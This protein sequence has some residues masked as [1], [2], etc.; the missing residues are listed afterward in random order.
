MNNA[1]K[2][3]RPGGRIQITTTREGD[4]A[5][6]T[7]RD[8]GI[9]IPTEQLT[10]VFD[11]FSQV[12]PAISHAHGG[13][14]IGLYLVRRLVDMHKGT[15]EALSEGPDRG[16]AFFVRLPA[17]PAVA[18]VPPR[19]AALAPAIAPGRRVLIVDDNVDAASC[20]A[21][22]LQAS[23]NE[24]HVAHDG[25]EAV[26]TAETVRP[27][28]IVLDI[29]LPQMDG[30]EVCRQIRQQPWAKTA[31]MIALTGWG[32]AGDRRKSREA[33]FDHHLVKPVD[34]NALLNLFLQTPGP[35]PDEPMTG[36]V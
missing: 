23:G 14:G 35:R 34:Q 31:T 33:G 12:D 10:R 30:F 2:Y 1:C 16:S 32:Q 17:A 9:G 36:G 27:E 21:L 22:L 6:V 4:T 29:G 3:T 24:T 20:L 18:A 13:L 5:L 19:P 25:F 7:V 28:I 11:L 26:Q 15:V 8:S